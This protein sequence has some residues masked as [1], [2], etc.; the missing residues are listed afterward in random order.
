MN[1][2]AQNKSDFMDDMADESGLVDGDGT[3]EFENDENSR[4]AS[5]QFFLRSHPGYEFSYLQKRKHVAIPVISTP[6]GNICQI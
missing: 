3:V 6:K 1:D 4:M 2:E 5:K